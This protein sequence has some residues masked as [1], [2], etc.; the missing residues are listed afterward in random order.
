RPSSMVGLGS[1]LLGVGLAPSRRY[2]DGLGLWPGG[3]CA[4][5]LVTRAARPAAGAG[6]FSRAQ[7]AAAAAHVSPLAAGNRAVGHFRS[8]AVGAVV[9]QH[10][11]RQ[12][13]ADLAVPH[14]CLGQRSAL[15]LVVPGHAMAA[16]AL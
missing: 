6:G 12:S 10:A 7:L 11:D 9:A 13:P 4:L 16:A 3:G 1:C 2:G 15:V 5:R 8:G 14:S